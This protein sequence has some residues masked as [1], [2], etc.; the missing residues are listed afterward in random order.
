MQALFYFQ[1]IIVTVIRLA[2]LAAVF[3][4]ELTI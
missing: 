4:K 1:A 3:E 2:P